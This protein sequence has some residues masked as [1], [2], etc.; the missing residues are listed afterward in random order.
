MAKNI[1]DAGKWVIVKNSKNLNVGDRIR[2]YDSSFKYGYTDSS[3]GINRHR[4]VKQIFE[5]NE[6]SSADETGRITCNDIFRNGFTKIEVW[7]P[8][9][10]VKKLRND[11]K[12]KTLI[13]SIHKCSGKYSLQIKFQSSIEI[14][15]YS[16]YNYRLKHKAIEAAEKFCNELGLICIIE[17]KSE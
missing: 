15:G 14:Y 12:E 4:F 9:G 6:V 7:V 5:E 3:M 13:I 2:Y 16:P 8:S 11:N 17:D 10:N 1:K